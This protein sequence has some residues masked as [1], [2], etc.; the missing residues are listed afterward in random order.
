MGCCG[1]RADALTVHRLGI[2]SHTVKFH[3]ATICGKLGAAN[4]T[5]AARTA[6]RQ[7]L[8]SL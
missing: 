7:G 6:L 4:R 5:E 2:S 8:I 1:Q 3:V